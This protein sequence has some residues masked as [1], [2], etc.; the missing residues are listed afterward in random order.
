ME[1]KI[2][3]IYQGRVTKAE[4]QLLNGSKKS[5]KK[6]EK[7]TLWKDCPEWKNLLF[8]HHE[9]FQNAVNYY[10]LAFASLA[11][12]PK[13]P[14]DNTDCPIYKLRCQ[15]K[16]KWEDFNHKGVLR[17]GMRKSVEKYLCSS[18]KE[19]SLLFE[20]GMKKVL[21]GNSTPPENLHKALDELIEEVDKGEGAIKTA[22]RQFFPMFCEKKTKATFPREKSALE[23]RRG[24]FSFQ[25]KLY[26]LKKDE[27]QSFADEVQYEWLANISK[28]HPSKNEKQWLETAVKKLKDWLKK[29]ESKTK[30][31]KKR[32]DSEK[33][34]EEIQKI[35]EKIRQKS[36]GQKIAYE[37]PNIKSYCGLLFKYFPSQFTYS[38]LSVVW[39][40][41]DPSE[42]EEERKEKWTKKIQKILKDKNK[43]EKCDE[44]LLIGNKDPI[45]FC[46]G[47][48]GYVFPSFTALLR[49][50]KSEPDAPLWKEFDIAAFK[51]ALT[52]VH[53][54]DEKTKEREKEKKKKQKRLD[55]MEK[56]QWKDGSEVII[57]KWQSTNKSDD[58]S[59]EEEPLFIGQFKENT[60]KR[61]FED[62]NPNAPG[63]PRIKK[64]R[65]L[66]EFELA[67]EYP[68][69][70]R[71]RTLRGF[72]EIQTKW[73]KILNRKQKTSGKQDPPGAVLNTEEKLKNALDD[74]QKKNKYS[75]GS[76]SLFNEL[77][78]PENW[79]IW[80]EL[81]E[82]EKT[83]YENKGFAENPLDALCDYY[84]L[85]EEI[86]K[87][88]EPVKFTPADPEHSRRLFRFGDACS[89]PKV[90]NKK[91]KGTKGKYGHDENSLSLRIPIMAKVQED[92]EWRE[93][94]VRL[95]YSAPRLFRDELRK[96]SN[97]ALEK[98]SWLQPMMKALDQKEPLEQDFWSCNVQLMPD[99]TKSGEWRY[100][101]NFSMGI[102]IEDVKLSNSSVD[103][104]KN[105]KAGGNKY[106]KW[107]KTSKW[108]G[109][110][111]T[112]KVDWFQNTN[113]FRCLSIDLG[114]RAAGAF[115]LIVAEANN[116]KP[117]WRFI[118]SADDKKW[119]ATAKTAGILRLPGED[120]KFFRKGKLETE[121][122][123]SKGR[124]AS[125][126]EW[127][128]AEAIISKLCGKNDIKDLLGG[129]ADQSG[130]NERKNLS[131]PE[132]ND[133][134]LVA[135]RRSQGRLSQYYR[136]VWMLGEESRKEKAL[137]EVKK[138]EEKT[139]WREL[140]EK[141]ES[142]TQHIQ[143]LI[144]GEIPSFQKSVIE[145][146]L[147]LANRILPLRGRKWEWIKHKG[148]KDC[149][150]LHQTEHKA[151]VTGIKIHGQRGLS[152]KRIEQIEELRRR[153][154]S[155]NQIQRREIG[156]PPLK[157]SEMRKN[158][159][160]D[161]CPDLLKKLEEIKKQRVNQ[162]A[163]LILAEAL[164]VRLKPSSLSQEVRLKKDIHGEYEKIRDPVNF[165]V[166]EDLSRYKMKQDRSRSEN[167]RLMQWSHRAVTD[168][169]KELCEP[170][171]LPV[172]E[173]VAAYSSKFCSRSG[174]PGFRAEEVTIKD[175]TR[176]PYKE[177]LNRE[178]KEDKEEKN[179]R[180]FLENLF[181]KLE[182]NGK[183]TGI[184]PKNGGPVFIPIKSFL[185][186][187]G[188]SVLKPGI[189]QADINAAINI[190]L[191]AISSPMAEEIHHRVRSECSS[192]DKIIVRSGSIETRRFRKKKPEIICEAEQ[193][194]KTNKN[195]DFFIDLAGVADFG[196]AEIQGV[197]YAS[198]KGVWTAV[199]KRQWDCCGEFNA[200]S[201]NKKT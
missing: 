132:L 27:Y 11:A 146:L 127:K 69:G 47:E 152:M 148:K 24:E 93:R 191:R 5:K 130:E 175:K 38:L 17:N 134:L 33:I 62:E 200:K 36:E 107:P 96:E 131:F 41:F 129:E 18:S 50:D 137:E 117:T 192:G 25:K 198:G 112:D 120:I 59:E 171:G 8:R 56:R 102:D 136:W 114:Q 72:G 71:R 89:W 76:A 12:N 181:Q 156:S 109:D 196:I 42:S 91:K 65:E 52:V 61:I 94:A 74:Y 43:K 90:K 168:K 85:K 145:N 29:D 98:A 35:E 14:S 13:R 187:K 180:E 173:A 68:Y 106:L 172:L 142:N 95:Y 53:Q 30:I 177:W 194:E 159:V 133:K 67:M 162:T 108:M 44:N 9:L 125:E 160:P 113:S 48:R 174:I 49:S 7:N 80:R 170:Y 147:L 70:L 46:R 78:K 167:S 144:K 51:E 55:W 201:L 22:G 100:L 37:K 81:S 60:E 58:E 1:K 23:K 84:E 164:G 124:K 31:L 57:K 158:P 195:S 4:I 105:C 157:L 119:V 20:E 104:E 161:P 169:L 149:H 135:I 88:R 199:K 54:I 97:E 126:E 115:A 86:E 141:G 15:M 176:R 165:I 154:Q 140:A 153:F 150:L 103:W 79:I 16:E 116:K 179:R 75:I 19:K 139:A 193:R 121:P 118:G 128:E 64:L 183:K 143:T 87:L 190:G 99:K 34:E 123:G 66:L 45:E 21:G 63:D 111:K 185:S 92:K 163:H 101:L 188:K 178:K 184:V 83:E 197:K 10:L 182:G 122:Y 138:Q 40:S 6:S 155:L 26:S 110:E 151:G 166:I 73:W 2:N 28:R 82:D 3:R 186:E 189:I 32:F 77:L 39:N